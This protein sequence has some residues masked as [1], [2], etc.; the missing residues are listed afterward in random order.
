MLLVAKTA[1]EGGGTVFPYLGVTVQP[2]E[3]D[4]IVWFNADSRG[5]RELHSIHGACP[6]RSGTK[7]ALSLWLRSFPHPALQT[8]LDGEHPSYRLNHVLRF[9]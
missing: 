4:L 1:E 7:V 5:S 9:V 2:E 6:I 8:P 3:G